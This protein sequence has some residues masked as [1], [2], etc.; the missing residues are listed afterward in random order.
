MLYD[1]KTGEKK[2]LTE[3]FDHWVGTFAWAPDSK[4]S[5]FVAED[6]RADRSIL[7]CRRPREQDSQSAVNPMPDGYDDDIAV[8]PGWSTTI[9]YL[10]ADR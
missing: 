9:W 3:D 4:R 8:D 7:C 1:R 6:K 10:L 2:N 5:I